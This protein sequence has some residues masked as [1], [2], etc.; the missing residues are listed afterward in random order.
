MPASKMAVFTSVMALVSAFAAGVL[1]VAPNAPYS[2]GV[3]TETAA[4]QEV[5]STTSA[6]SLVYSLNV[7]AIVHS[8]S[9]A[10]SMSTGGAAP[11]VGQASTGSAAPGNAPAT[12][13]ASQPVV[14]PTGEPVPT[15]LTTTDSA[16]NPT[17]VTQ[18]ESSALATGKST[19]YAPTQSKE[20]QPSGSAGTPVPTSTGASNAVGVVRGVALGAAA[21]ALVFLF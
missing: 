1:G 3:S 10:V 4:P 6:G 16:G 19:E 17:A 21:M 14:T 7:C 8:T 9:C 11:P 20:Q 2:N 5:G 13:G 15:V 12:P 18:V